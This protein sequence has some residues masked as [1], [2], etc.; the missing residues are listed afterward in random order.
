MLFPGVSLKD[1]QDILRQ[2]KRGKLPIIDGSR[3]LV[4]IMA[5]TDLKKRGEYPMATQDESGQLRVGAA[6]GTREVDKQRLKLLVEAG[7]DAVVIDSSQGNSVYQISMIKF[8]KSS[9]P[10]LQVIAGNGM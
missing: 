1:A 9:Y 8:I 4:S 10:D 6:I 2:S 3:N 7:V 5:R